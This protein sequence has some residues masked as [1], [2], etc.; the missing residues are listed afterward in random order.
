MMSVLSLGNKNTKIN[1][2]K[3]VSFCDHHVSTILNNVNGKTFF[4][5]GKT[6]PASILSF[7]AI[8]MAFNFQGNFYKSNGSQNPRP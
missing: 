8:K 4:P 5:T 6:A 7:H 2:L 3:L 1:Q